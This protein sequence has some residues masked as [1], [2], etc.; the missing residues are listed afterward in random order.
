MGSKNSIICEHPNLQMQR[1]NGAK[2][3]DYNVITSYPIEYVHM[4]CDQCN[5]N[6]Y[7]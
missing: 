6:Q 7:Y 4:I 3:P 5:M 1:V 2:N